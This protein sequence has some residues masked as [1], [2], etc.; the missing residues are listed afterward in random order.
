MKKIILL[1]AIL[2]SVSACQIQSDDSVTPTNS[3]NATI[4]PSS[5]TGGSD[6]KVTSY[7]DKKGRDDT[8]SYGSYTFSYST[9]GKLS[10]KSGGKVAVSG[11]WKHVVDSGKNKF[12]ITLTTTNSALEE[13]N[14]DWIIVS[15]T[16]NSIQLTNTSG[17]NG[18][19]TTLTFSR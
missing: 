8:S 4:S 3:A 6:W 13:F 9:D 17:G 5:I 16:S 1:F 11:T 2:A 7:V 14:E 10:V 15:M 18:G 19:T 12:Y